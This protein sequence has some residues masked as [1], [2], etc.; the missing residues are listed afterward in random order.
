M[1]ELLPSS[2]D[3]VADLHP[4]AAIRL[5]A[6]DLDGTL[7]HA[8]PFQSQ[9][10][11]KVQQYLRSLQR[12]GV[13]FTLATGR[14]FS[15]VK[16]LVERLRLRADTPLVLYNGSVVMEWGSARLL[17]RATLATGAL[18]KVLRQASEHACEALAYFCQHPLEARSSGDVP[19]ERVIGWRF[20]TH[21]DPRKDREFNG[22][23]IVWLE[24]EDDRNKVAPCALLLKVANPTVVA[25][26]SA[27]LESI[28]EVSITRSG[29]TYLEVRPLG[30]DK[31][32]GLACVAEH[33]GVSQRQ[34]LVI[35]DN[36]NDAE[37]LN[38]AGIGVSISGASP[39]ATKHAN[40]VCRRTTFEGVIEVLAVVRNARRYF[41]QPRGRTVRV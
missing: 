26:L 5:I 24:T 41:P 9:L 12:Y 2:S 28:H 10:D 8:A 22:C 18:Q 6:A 13:R 14:T 15:G 7:V 11:E 3:D 17:R 1:P 34:V 37:M 27:A 4:F 21:S 19:I 16:A 40:Y 23:P 25:P 32:I 38:W 31:A 20:G 35:G 33:I 29:P 39:A 30:S 36:D